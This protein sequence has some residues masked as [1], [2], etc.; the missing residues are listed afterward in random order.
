MAVPQ[1]K[2]VAFP[3]SMVPLSGH[4]SPLATSTTSKAMRLASTLGLRAMR[5]LSF[6]ASHHW[7]TRGTSAR[8]V[9]LVQVTVRAHR[10]ATGVLPSGSGG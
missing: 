6:L 10:K 1:T 8:Q 7:R 3:R 4:S 5:F 9:G 2:Q